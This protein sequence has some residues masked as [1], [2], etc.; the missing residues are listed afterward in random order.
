MSPDGRTS[1]LPQSSYSVDGTERVRYF[2]PQ[3]PFLSGHRGFHVQAR[4]LPKRV[5]RWRNGSGN[6]PEQ[7]K[8]SLMGFRWGGVGY[9][10]MAT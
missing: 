1:A 8:L 3:R 7:L 10:G 5:E 9:T 4:R 6:A 2:W